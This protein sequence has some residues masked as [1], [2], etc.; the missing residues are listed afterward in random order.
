MRVHHPGHDEDINSKIA[1]GIKNAAVVLV[2]PSRSLQMLKTGSKLLNYADQT[3]TPILNIKT[4]ENFQPRDWLGAILALTR[5]ASTDF[6]EVLKSL[7]SMEIQT[8]TL[9]LERDEK[10]EPQP[11]EKHLFHGGTRSGNVVATYKQFGK[12]FSMEF[13]VF[14][15]L[16]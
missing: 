11:T 9:V 1:N 6:N 14:S 15:K 12:E 10:T 16:N 3:K 8:N 13:E 4:H 5:S 2:F 7:I